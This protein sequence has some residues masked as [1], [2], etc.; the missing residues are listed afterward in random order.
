MNLKPHNPFRTGVRS[1][2]AL[3]LTA[4]LFA[5]AQS[6][7]DSNATSSSSFD[8]IA[9][10]NI[11]NPNRYGSSGYRPVRRGAPT[12]SLTGTMSYRQGMFAFF[13]GTSSD[14]HKVIQEGGT[15]AG[16]KVTKIT[17]AG[18]QLQGGGQPIA[19]KVGGAMRQDGDNWILSEPGQWDETSVSAAAA[20][21]PASSSSAGTSGTTASAPS[22]AGQPNDVLRRLMEKRQQELK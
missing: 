15:I 9:Q 1:L 2:A 6:T 16:Y 4:A 3:V 20:E 14:Y 12:F 19:M 10:R 11:F 13:D 5:R 17:F 7:D 8:I 22:P 18:A 21:T